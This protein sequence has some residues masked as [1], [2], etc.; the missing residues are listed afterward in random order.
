MSLSLFPHYHHIQHYTGSGHLPKCHLHE[1]T[2]TT[3][4]S[5]DFGKDEGSFEGCYLIAS[6]GPFLSLPE[7]PWA[8]LHSI[9]FIASQVG[10]DPGGQTWISL[11]SKWR[12][13]DSSGGV[14]HLW[15]PEWQA[16]L[17]PEQ[18]LPGGLSPCMLQSPQENK[19]WVT[20]SLAAGWQAHVTPAA[21][22]WLNS[23]SLQGVG[24][25][26]TLTPLGGDDK[27]RLWESQERDEPTN[28]YGSQ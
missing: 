14:S 6:S 7:I 18:A 11:L 5:Q 2:R 8:G 28:K 25:S 9:S 23:H 17:R 24:V 4:R 1:W 27:I 20:S 26:P 15:S 13:S 16:G 22:A 10:R 3:V 12:H 19:S 21:D